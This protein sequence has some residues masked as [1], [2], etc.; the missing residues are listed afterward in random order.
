MK[1]YYIDLEK[2]KIGNPNSFNILKILSLRVYIKIIVM[3]ILKLI[4]ITAIN[5]T[6]TTTPPLIMTVL[7]KLMSSLIH[8]L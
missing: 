8:P 4:E 5:S 6:T 7:L 3:V 2:P 1:I